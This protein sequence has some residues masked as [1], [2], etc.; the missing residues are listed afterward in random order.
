MAHHDKHEEVLKKLQEMLA[1][2]EVEEVE[3]AFEMVSGEE[4][5]FEFDLDDDEEEEEEVAE[6]EEEEEEAAAI[7]D[8]Q[9]LDDEEEEEF[10]EEDEEDE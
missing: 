4:L 2:G 8:T 9:I 5:S 7:E 6:E 10:D 1:G 3:L